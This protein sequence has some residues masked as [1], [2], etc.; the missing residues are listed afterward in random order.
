MKQ[1]PFYSKVL[2]FL[3]L[4]NCMALF[5]SCRKETRVIIPD[6]YVDFTLS[7]NDPL[8][9]DLNSVGNSVVVNSSYFG[10][11]SSGYKDHGIIIYRASQTEFYAFDRTC[12]WEEALDE[13]VDLDLPSDLS[14][15]CPNCGSTYILPSYGYPDN[16]G[17]ALY[18]LKSYQTEF[19]GTNIWVYNRVK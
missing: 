15:E 17:P 3:V 12:T 9:I 10:S 11:S 1:L 4:A 6:T 19:D 5:H 16:D 7:L 18:P 13:A 2:I 14:A 8:F